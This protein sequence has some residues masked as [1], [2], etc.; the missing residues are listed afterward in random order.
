MEKLQNAKINNN[1]PV[2]NSISDNENGRAYSSKLM[3]LMIVVC[4]SIDVYGL[5]LY[6][7]I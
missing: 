3:K 2:W 6:I 5:M 7:T 1:K 4:V